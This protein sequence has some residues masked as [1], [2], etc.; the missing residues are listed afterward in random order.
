MPNRFELVKTES[1]DHIAVRDN[2]ANCTLVYI[3]SYRPTINFWL[4]NQ[5]VDPT[6]CAKGLYCLYHT[7][8]EN[9]L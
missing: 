6:L 8:E 1:Q 7:V 4:Q 9:L 5:N 3:A 2:Q